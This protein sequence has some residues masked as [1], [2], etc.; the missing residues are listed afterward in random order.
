MKLGSISISA[1]CFLSARF[2]RF[3]GRQTDCF[4][5]LTGTSRTGLLLAPGKVL[6]QLFGRPRLAFGLLPFGSVART[7]LAR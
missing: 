1:E 5:R 7:I 2:V 6:A 3:C 4:V